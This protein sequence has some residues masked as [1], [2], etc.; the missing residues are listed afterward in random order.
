[1]IDFVYLVVYNEKHFFFRFSIEILGTENKQNF[2]EADSNSDYNPENS[3]NSPCYEDMVN[4]MLESS[5]GKK[6]KAKSSTR[7]PK[8]F[9]K[10]RA[11]K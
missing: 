7:K 4:Q 6:R 9:K 5:R 2:N 11:K 1:M 3:F 10:G 8:R